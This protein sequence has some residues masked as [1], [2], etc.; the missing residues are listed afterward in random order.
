MQSEIHSRLR[1]CRD[2]INVVPSAQP[3]AG[4]SERVGAQ[5]VVLMT[6]YAAQARQGRWLGG[7][8]LAREEQWSAPDV[9]RRLQLVLAGVWLLDAIL[10]FQQFMFSNGFSQMLAGTAPGNP[11]VIASPITWAARIIA[12]HG[13]STNAV[14]ALVQLLL[15]LGIAL[16]PTV[17][18]ALA[19]SVVWALG[20]WWF[21][22]GL[23]GILNGGASPVNGAP[24]AVIIYALL[25][26]LLWPP[27]H[28]KAA[29]FVAGR[30]TGPV[31]ARVLW[32]VLWGSLAY[33]A[34]QPATNAPKALGGMV[35]GMASGEPGW[36]ASTDNSLGSYLAGHGPGFAVLFAVVFAVVAAGVFLPPPAVK[37]V[38]VLAVVT[39]AFIWLAEGLGGILTGGGTDP[40]SGPLLVLLAVCYWPLAS[41]S[42]TVATESSP[43]SS[44]AA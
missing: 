40:N 19:A 1:Q 24:G 37:G 22:E 30:F 18:P 15:A 11:S 10:Q 44:A 28:E 36:L 9:R 25:A 43:S 42:A 20:V 6:G 8:G 29:S 39:A 33:F 4:G 21:G 32:L 23:G 34:L 35:S 5:K 7:I 41:R 2:A 16:R 27:R 14:F 3:V 13:T 38:L 12:H 31:T 26:V 17:R